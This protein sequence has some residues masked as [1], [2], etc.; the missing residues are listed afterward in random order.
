MARRLSKGP[1][2]G[3]GAAMSADGDIGADAWSGRS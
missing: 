2:M 3:V 1:G